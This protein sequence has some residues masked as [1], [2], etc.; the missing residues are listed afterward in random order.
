M[1]KPLYSPRIQQSIVMLFIYQFVFYLIALFV[2]SF[3]FKKA[4]YSE[5]DLGIQIIATVSSFAMLLSWIARK[6][7]LGFRDYLTFGGLKPH[8]L[9]PMFFTILGADLVISEL[10]N[11]LQIFLPMDKH[12]GDTLMGL[13][14]P[15]A[16]LI[17]SFFLVVLIAPALEETVFRGLIL[18]GFLTHYSISKAIITSAFLFGLF[19]MNIWQFQGAFIWGIIAGWWFVKTGSLFFCIIGHV[20]MN[21]I[22][23]IVMLFKH[24]YQWIIPGF[25]SDF[26]ELTF[27]PLW[28]TLMGL[29]MLILG[30]TILNKN[31]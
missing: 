15:E 2:I 8:Y 10:S 3:V 1:T 30:I 24:R 13:F 22:G 4:G 31:F 28:L 14:S 27:Q 9:M 16:G 5:N 29:I 17:E 18:R 21:A 12:I 11:R 20:G 19:H 7:R 25:S 26:A 23:F 6:H